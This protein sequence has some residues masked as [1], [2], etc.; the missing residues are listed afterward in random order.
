[1]NEPYLGRKCYN[2]QPSTVS[3]GEG[4]NGDNGIKQANRQTSKQAWAR[5]I[6]VEHFQGV[7]LYVLL[8]TRIRK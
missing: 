3:K 1:M 2:R 7:S 4:N 6:S 8:H 5:D